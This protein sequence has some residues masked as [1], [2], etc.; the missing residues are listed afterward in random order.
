MRPWPQRLG[1]LLLLLALSG[2]G[3]AH[4]G[5]EAEIEEITVEIARFGESAER[6]LQRAI[7]YRVLGRLKEAANDLQRA[8]RLESDRPGLRRELARVQ[9]GQGQTNEAL[10]TVELGLGLKSIEPD[11]RAALLAMKAGL[12]AAKG[13]S[14]PALENWT[15]ALRLQP[16]NVD[17]HHSRSQLLREMGR[18]E[19]RLKRIDEAIAVTG[20]GMLEVERIDALLDAGRWTEALPRIESELAS[21]RLRGSWLLR[22]GRALLGMSRADEARKDLE[23]ASAEIRARLGPGIREASLLAEVGLAEELLGHVEE[24]KR[25]YADALAAGAGTYVRERLEKLKA[26]RKD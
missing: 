23:A 11:E 4:E 10:A 22:R 13:R 17:W 6:L 25:W 8:A 26:A 24:A 12:F 19:E 14:E 2:K 20:S 18:H 5:P 16:E 9:E 15:E 7:E 21:S 1:T 3:F